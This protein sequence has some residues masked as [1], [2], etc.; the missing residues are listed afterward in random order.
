MADGPGPDNTEQSMA[1]SLSKPVLCAHPECPVCELN[2][3]LIQV[4]AES[5]AWSDLCEHDC[6]AYVRVGPSHRCVH[7][8]RLDVPVAKYRR[9]SKG[10]TRRMC[11]FSVLAV[12]GQAALLVVVELKSGVAYAD[13]LDQLSEGLR[14]IH[15]YFEANGLT[16]SPRACFVVG[17]DL[18]K[19]RFA[20]RDR[21]TSLRFGSVPVRLDILK[22]GDP[23]EL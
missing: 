17:R 2:S 4:G 1:V 10:E 6:H 9:V 8:L 7:G 21:L 22:C 19:L 16:A 20:L 13:E 15:N 5:V 14:L 23:L 12:H 18:D 11:D 3:R